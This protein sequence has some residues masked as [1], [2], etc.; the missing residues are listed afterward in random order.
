MKA[1]FDNNI[2]ISALISPMGIAARLVTHWESGMFSVVVTADLLSELGRAL[3]YERIRKRT[4]FT[5]ADNRLFVTRVREQGIECQRT[6]TV[7]VCR[8]PQDD[9]VLEAALAGGADYIVTGDNDLLVLRDF[10]GISIVTPRQFL[11]VLGPGE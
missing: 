2:I 6:V 3:G 10:E 8:D 7:R 9:R 5:D 4:G 1:V 11:A